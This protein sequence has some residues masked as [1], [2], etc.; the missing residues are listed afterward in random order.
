MKLSF[1]LSVNRRRRLNVKKSSLLWTICA[2]QLVY[3]MMRLKKY[4]FSVFYQAN[5]RVFTLL[6][7]KLPQWQ[8]FIASSLVASWCQLHFS[9]I[10]FWAELCISI[11]VHFQFSIVYG[12]VF[13]R[14]TG[15]VLLSEASM[16]HLLAL[17]RENGSDVWWSLPIET[18]LP[19]QVID[20]SG[21]S[22]TSDDYVKGGDILD[23]WFDSGISWNAVLP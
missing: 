16:D 4:L 20:R 15:V 12:Y 3:E 8:L 9:Q 13:A 7:M 10:Q 17:I 5:Y 23:I 14:F 19:Q 22:G 2:I 21:A 1:L 18:L 11:V 6:P